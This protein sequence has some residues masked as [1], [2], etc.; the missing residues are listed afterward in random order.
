M[1]RFAGASLVKFPLQF[2]MGLQRGTSTRLS[3]MAI[4]GYAAKD[5]VC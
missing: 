1:T 3:G 2:K 5:G 4:K